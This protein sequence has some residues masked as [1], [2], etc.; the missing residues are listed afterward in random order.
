MSVPQ[1]PAGD[2]TDSL[3]GDITFRE[4]SFSYFKDQK[5][6]TLK[7]VSFTIKAGD[8]VGIIGSTGS[9]K[10]TLVSLIPRLYDAD[11]GEVLVGG[12]NVREI[13]QKTLRKR[14]S[15][16]LQQNTLFSGTIE[17]NLRWGKEDATPE[18]MVHACQIAQAHS[19]ITSFPDGYRT[20]IGQG[21][22]TLS[23]GQ[24]QRLCIARALLKEP[25]I[26]I[27]DDSTSAVDTKTDEA[28]RRALEEKLTGVTRLVIAQRISSI[29]G[30]D[31][32]IVLEKG[33]IAGVGT[34]EQLLQSC[35]PY[36]EIYYSQKDREEGKP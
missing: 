30:A 18:E 24:K 33:A 28:I 7:N 36:Q 27:L 11:R 15:V 10:T 1:D 23:G 3:S 31:Q 9:G 5:T 4:V 20:R 29:M 2:C 34:H 19:F 16:V 14:V 22:S 6:P 25:G 32:I 21:G 8:F 13:P 35:L 26:L 17:D 12:R